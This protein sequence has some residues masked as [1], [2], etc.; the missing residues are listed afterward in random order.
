MRT[1]TLP[2][3]IKQTLF[4][5]SHFDPVVLTASR[6]ELLAKTFE[7]SADCLTRYFPLLFANM[8]GRLNA[9]VYLKFGGQMKKKNYTFCKVGNRLTSNM[10][11]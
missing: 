6:G 11:A 3:R 1:N 7:G 5:A 2:I 8:N 9:G 4:F 10:V